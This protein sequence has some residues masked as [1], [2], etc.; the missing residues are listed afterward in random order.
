MAAMPPFKGRII[1][2]TRVS[3]MFY[4]SMR[5]MS[6]GDVDSGAPEENHPLTQKPGIPYLDLP[7]I[8]TAITI[9]GKYRAS[10]PPRGREAEFRTCRPAVDLLPPL[11][12]DTT[13]CT[14]YT[15]SIIILIVRYLT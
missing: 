4:P 15:I 12:Y 9:V 5:T 14:R 10:D 6:Y 2:H 3:C 13:R 8:T 7:S 1:V 11:T